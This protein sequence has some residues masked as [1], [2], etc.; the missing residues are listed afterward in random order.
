MGRIWC[1]DCYRLDPA[2]RIKIPHEVTACCRGGKKER[3]Y[4]DTPPTSGS[5][6]KVMKRLLVLARESDIP[7]FQAQGPPFRMS[8]TL[9]K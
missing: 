5:E 8:L 9:S 4:T 1:F 3:K 6:N 2:L 7:G